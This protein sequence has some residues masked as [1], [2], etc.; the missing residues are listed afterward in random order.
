MSDSYSTRTQRWPNGYFTQA[1]KLDQCF[2][3]KMLPITE[4]QSYPP[5][6]R[7]SLLSSFRVMRK[8]CRPCDCYMLFALMCRMFICAF[9]CNSL[10]CCKLPQIARFI[11]IAWDP[12]GADRTGPMLALHTSFHSR[13][14]NPRGYYTFRPSHTKT[15]PLP[16]E[17]ESNHWFFKYDKKA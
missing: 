2:L 10:S 12:P 1:W 5:H 13:H 11:G 4:I 14:T 6:S 8:W 16:C 3:Y 17:P 7:G 9:L 15:V